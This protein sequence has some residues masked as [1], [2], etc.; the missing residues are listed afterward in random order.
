[1]ATFKIG[2]NK[3]KLNFSFRIM[4]SE[5]VPNIVVQGS[6][7]SRTG[8]ENLPAFSVADALFSIQSE[9]KRFERERLAW[10]IERSELKVTVIAF[11]TIISCFY[12]IDLASPRFYHLKLN[13]LLIKI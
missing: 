4:S 2:I 8:S 12:L 5:A 10:S 3:S 7:G 11:T 6:G 13:V 9:F 1:L